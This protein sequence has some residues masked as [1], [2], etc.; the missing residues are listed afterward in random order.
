VSPG[1]VA[2]LARF[3]VQHPGWT[4]SRTGPDLRRFTAVRGGVTVIAATLTE[5]RSRIS[6][7]EQAWPS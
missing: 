6:Q 5:L 1:A 7:C 2:D 4:V 3:K